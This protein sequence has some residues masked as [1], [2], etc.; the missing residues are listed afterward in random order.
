MAGVPNPS[1]AAVKAAVSS[2]DIASHC[3]RRTRGVEKTVE[4]I[5]ALLLSLCTAT[6]MLGV[7]LLKDEMKEI[8]EE[9]K[10]HVPCI[11]DQPG[12]A[13]YSTTKYITKGV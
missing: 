10:R 12:V 4:M 11:P 2:T 8:W 6:D 5:E 1:M 13:L 3:Q 9:Q 7:L